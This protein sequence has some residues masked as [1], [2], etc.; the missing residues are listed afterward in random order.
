[1]RCPSGVSAGRM[2][3]ALKQVGY[4][5]LRVAA[6]SGLAVKVRFICE[7]ICAVGRQAG[8]S[9]PGPVPRISQK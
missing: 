9:S 3:A 2:E 4:L 6:E 1:M 8:R 5:L 7:E